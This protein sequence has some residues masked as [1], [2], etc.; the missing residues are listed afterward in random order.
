MISVI[1]ILLLIL[2]NI[3]NLMFGGPSLEQVM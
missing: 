1:L 2:R 3:I